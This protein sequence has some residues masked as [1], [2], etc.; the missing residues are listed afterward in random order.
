MHGLSRLGA[1][2]GLGAASPS[3]QHVGEGMML[4]DWI[5]ELPSWLLGLLILTLCIGGAV[6]GLLATRSKARLLFGRPPGHND[7]VSYYLGAFG[8]LYGLTL[9]LIAVATWQNYTDVDK[10]VA[11]EAATLRVLHANVSWYPR[12]ERAELSQGLMAY[13]TYIIEQEWPAQRRGVLLGT[14]QEQLLAF[15]RPLM[16]FDP[17]SEGEKALHQETLQSLDRYLELRGTRLSHVGAGV[18]GLVWLVLIVGAVLTVAITYCFSMKSIW[19]HLVLTVVLSGFL[20]LVIYLI[21]MLDYP[22]RG[23]LAV[24]P[25]RFELAR[26]RMQTYVTV[27]E[28]YVDD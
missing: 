13:A 4:L 11:Q 8:V 5:Y 26:E 24:G 1:H 2:G 18:P 15:R 21:V 17:E 22:F 16:E 25:G 3:V 6:F 9:G 27:V 23:G 7:V 10:L 14:G 12:S 19:G 28:P 20:G